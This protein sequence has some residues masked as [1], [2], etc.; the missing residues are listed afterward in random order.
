MH[1]FQNNHS[2]FAA[3]KRGKT[4]KERE[5]E[6][7]LITTEGNSIAVYIY[8]VIRNDSDVNVNH[9]VKELEKLSK[10][11]FKAIT[12]YVNSD[13]GEVGAGIALFNW[14]NR[15]GLKVE[16]VVDG[17]AASMAAIIMS[18]PKHSVKMHKYA[19]LMYHRV[20]GDV[21][22]TSEELRASAEMIDT[23]ENSIIE[24]LAE[25]L[26]DTHDNVKAKFFNATDKWISAREAL[27]LGLCNEI[28]E[29]S[30]NIKEINGEV[31]A[32]EAFN[33]YK[34]QITNQKTKKMFKD[35]KSFAV[36]LNLLES[37]LD[38]EAVVLKKVQD[39][40]AENRV[41]KK[42]RDEAR[43]AK[44]DAES[45]VKAFNESRVKNLIDR[46]V[47]DKKIDESERDTYKQLAEQ[48]FDLCERVL[49]KQQAPARVANQLDPSGNQIPES[50][51]A[52]TFDDY[53]KNNKL[54]NLKATN[55][56][57]YSKLYAAKF[58]KEPGKGG[59]YVG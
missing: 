27:A 1:V 40:I 46:A 18:N 34:N 29:S 25:R 47:S 20:R 9:I 13:G 7:V 2:T 37:D 48:D 58:G 52:W 54:E 39:V 21:Y 59:S 22:G 14:L 35:K 45:K 19:K 24:M 41:L 55:W 10:K 12:L 43:R 16:W 33:Y 8:G 38:D 56:D 6:E 32:H 3:Q 11:Q 17:V 44:D 28:L 4:M 23:F 49:S 5:R 42:E 36:A 53:H 26:R 57:V 30:N 15:S 50:Q 51:K 31:S